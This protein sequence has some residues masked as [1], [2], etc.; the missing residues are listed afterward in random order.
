MG[1]I[2]L[3]YYVAILFTLSLVIRFWGVAD[4]KYLTK[5]D[6]LFVSA[7]VSYMEHGNT[8]NITWAHP[9]FNHILNYATMKMLG[10]NPYG[11]R[12]KNILLGSIS[13]VLLLLVAFQIFHSYESSFLAGLLLSIDP[14]HIAYSRSTHSEIPVLCFFL[15]FFYLILIY[16]ND[17]KDYLFYA[18][19]CLGLAMA[20]KSYYAIASMITIGFTIT[21]SFKESDNR[22]TEIINISSKLILL[23][24]VVY[25]LTYVPWFARGYDFMEFLQMKMDSLVELQSY[26]PSF[27]ANYS[28]LRDGGMPW[29]W[30]VKP[31]GYGWQFYDDGVFGGFS[32]FLNNPPIWM[33]TLP[34]LF[35]TLY[36]TVKTRDVG[37]FLI[38]SIFMSTYL[39]LLILKRPIFNYSA[40]TIV[41]F[42][43]LFISFSVISVL[44]K[45]RNSGLLYKLVI[46]MVSVWGLYLYPL[47]VGR[48]VPVALY[49]PIIMM[50]TIYHL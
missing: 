16:L 31:L 25:L 18:G 30:F 37:F 1:N 28:V 35:Y 23:P 2:K 19:L 6:G 26:S 41:P 34:A 36:K 17:K 44:H 50:T 15:L 39:L 42:A 5:D 10:N 14:L 45:F 43:Y 49:R 4:E 13:S 9:P 3:G 8:E 38:I 32:L 33:L 40:L 24:S 21:R 12:L 47:A 27:F 29:E 11:W 7:A 20:S 22:Y 48:I 46:I